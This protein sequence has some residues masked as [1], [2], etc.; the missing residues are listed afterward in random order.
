M[1]T[2]V[3]NYYLGLTG[4]K[5]IGY[6]HLHEKEKYSDLV[7]I[8]TDNYLELKVKY[9]YYNFLPENLYVISGVNPR[10]FCSKC[11]PHVDDCSELLK[12]ICRIIECSC[13]YKT[14]TLIYTDCV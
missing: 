14:N 12:R 7:H 11:K 9:W 10:E 3:A 8:F 2:K 1:M 5:N 4:D 6:D 13:D